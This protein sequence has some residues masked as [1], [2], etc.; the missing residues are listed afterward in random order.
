MAFIEG[1]NLHEDTRDIFHSMVLHG[2]SLVSKIIG[3]FAI[4]RPKR[5]RP[6]SSLQSKAL[7]EPSANDGAKPG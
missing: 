2:N 7:S 4:L 5:G 1:P 6:G 3:K